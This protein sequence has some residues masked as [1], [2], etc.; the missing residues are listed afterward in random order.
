MNRRQISFP[1]LF[2]G[3]LIAM[4]LF[5]PYFGMDT[6]SN[7]Q[8]HGGLGYFPVWEPPT[9]Q[10]ALA[11]LTESGVVPEGGVRAS[12]LA[13]RRNVVG[14]TVNAIVLFLLCLLGFALLGTRGGQ[15]G[16]MGQDVGTSD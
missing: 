7:G 13:I 10:H 4:V 3:G 14:L 16:S 11:L 6:T 5:P 1:V 15:R 2:L 9:Q 8:I 12:D